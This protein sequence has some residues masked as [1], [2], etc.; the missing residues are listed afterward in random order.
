[1]AELTIIKSLH[2]GNARGAQIVVCT[3]QHKTGVAAT[4]EPFVALA[5]VFDP[6]YYPTGLELVLCAG[7]EHTR[8]HLHVDHP[9]NDIIAA[10]TAYGQEAAAYL[11]LGK[12]GLA[13]TIAPKYFGSWT[14]N[15]P[16]IRQNSARSTTRPVRLVLME[17]LDGSTIQNHYVKNKSDS[18]AKPDASHM[19]EEYRLEVLGQILEGQVSQLRAGV[20][21]GQIH[22]ENVIIVPPSYCG[23]EA[24]HEEPKPRA[25]LIGYKRAMLNMVPQGEAYAD[26]KGSHPTLLFDPVSAFVSTGV[27]EHTFGMVG[28]Y[29]QGIVS[30]FEGWLPV[31]M[32][33]DPGLRRVWA[34]GRFG[35]LTTP[36]A[37]SGRKR[38]R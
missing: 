37:A 33:R 12:A 31:D 25:V 16:V 34:L 4:E 3:I 17:Y 8:G 38:K 27:E 6:F 5:K 10:E 24:E 35:R 9:R 29:P 13:G 18:L 23:P 15:L 30:G 36:G 14:F 11:L 20:Y 21:K 19:P 28:G 1:M 32:Q 26:L 7:A 22:A 2:I